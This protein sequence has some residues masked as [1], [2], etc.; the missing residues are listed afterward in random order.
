MISSSIN[1]VD[2]G[3]V[4]VLLFFIGIGIARGFTN[5]F[6]GLFTWVGAFF[7]TTK[8]LPYG[9]YI[10]HKVI[11]TIIIAQLVS[12]FIIF[13]ISLILLVWM[14]KS[15]AHAV[16]NSMLSGVDRSLGILSGF[17]RAT[18]F[19][20]AGYMVALMFWKPGETHPMLS[21]SRFKP[22]FT[23]T[24]QLAAT[25]LIPKEFIP[26]PL[27]QHLFGKESQDKEKSSDELVKSLSSPK[28]QQKPKETPSEEGKSIKIEK[29]PAPPVKDE[30]KKNEQ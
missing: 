12:A 9:E 15:V 29:P 21:E 24:A 17:F 30:Q 16:H 3:V 27:M 2:L 13:L 22:Y 23:A 10:A 6:F 11:H 4:A 14:V 18:V 5:D 26:K 20:T 8:L 19:L 1:Y 28:P 25:Y 7:I